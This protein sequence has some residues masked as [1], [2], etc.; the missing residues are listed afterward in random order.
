MGNQ[1]TEVE[2]T[3]VSEQEAEAAFNAGLKKS[4]GDRGQADDEPKE[5]VEKAK[6]VKEEKTKPED[7]DEPL[8]TKGK[9][10]S[11]KTEDQPGKDKGEKSQESD[12]ADAAKEEREFAGLKESE[13]KAI[14]VKAAQFDELKA[15]MDKLH[16]RT[17]G[18]LGNVQKAIKDLQSKPKGGIKVVKEQ[19]KR[20]SADFPELAERLAEDLNDVLIPQEGSAAAKL[21]PDEINKIV[22]QRLA[23]AKFETDLQ[24][25]DTL[26]PDRMDVIASDAYKVWFGL[27][28]PDAKEAIKTSREVDFVSTAITAFKTWRDRNAQVSAGAAQEAAKSAKQRDK[29]LDDAIAPTAGTP[30]ESGKRALTPEE[31]FN[32]G[33][34]KVRGNRR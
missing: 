29:R 5:E 26:H 25:L 8:E 22:E 3:E 2:A 18:T 7:G 17:A 30:A 19:L 24:R 15:S 14:A 20:L 1:G 28:S 10:K 13:W 31:E 6:E 11:E 23:A 32:A 16:D 27:Q 9:E 12:A 21:D 34:K 33:I 4:R